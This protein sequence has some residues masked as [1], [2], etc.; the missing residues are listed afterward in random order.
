MSDEDDSAAA[1]EPRDIDDVT[2]GSDPAETGIPKDVIED[3]PEEAQRSIVDDDGGGS[4]GVFDGMDAPE[5]GNTPI[6][7]ESIDLENA[8]FVALGVLLTLGLFWQL[9]TIVAA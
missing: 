7:R 8:L 9:V 5:P 4:G 6:E 2:V 1:S 3:L